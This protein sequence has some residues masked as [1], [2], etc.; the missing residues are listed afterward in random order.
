MNS[1]EKILNVLEAIDKRFDRVDVRLEKMDKHMET[2][3]KRFGKVEQQLET[4]NDHLR[5][6]EAGQTK[7]EARQIKLEEGMGFV[8]GSVIELEKDTGI[9]IDGIVALNEKIDR[10]EKHVS[11]QDEVILRRVFPVALDGE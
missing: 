6:L 10:I 9:L 5:N 8:R 3:D 4:V 1:E 2:M 11:S 7:L